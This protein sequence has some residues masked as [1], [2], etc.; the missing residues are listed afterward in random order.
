MG[1]CR[2]VGQDTSTIWGRDR[3][4]SAHVPELPHG[5][6]TLL[7]SDIE[8][9]T[10]HLLR[11]GER[12]PAVLARQRELL[13]DA[14]EAHRGVPD[15]TQGDG[16]FAAFPTAHGAIMAAIAAQR[17]LAAEPWPDGESV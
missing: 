15:D 12:Y 1:A 16:S 6:V 11:L 7:F 2:S 8:G 5:T 9:S 14:I 3:S 4:W 17:A 13:T 10:R